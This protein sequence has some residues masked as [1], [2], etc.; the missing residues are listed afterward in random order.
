MDGSVIAWTIGIILFLFFLKSA[1][2]TPKSTSRNKSREAPEWLLK[3]WQSQLNGE[4]GFPE[5]Y[6]HEP[7]ERQ[8]QALK[9][10]GIEIPPKL[11]K[12]T[13][14]DLIGLKL[15]ADEADIEIA[16]FFKR[17]HRNLSQT[18]GREIARQ[19]SNSAELLNAWNNR[20]PNA[21]TKAQLKHFGIKI[22]KET[23]QNQ[24]YELLK[25]HNASEHQFSELPMRQ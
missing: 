8:I 10:Y 22:T 19:V 6:Q 24:A 1:S 12:G 14:S 2:T 3:R 17:N 5:W 18:E 21:L 13:A 9:Q 7:S 15:P 11:T 4:P 20:P 23:T 16:K 25:N